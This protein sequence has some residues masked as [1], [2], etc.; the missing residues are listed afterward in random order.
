MSLG[1]MKLAGLY[2]TLLVIGFLLVFVPP[3]TVISMNKKLQKEEFTLQIFLPQLLGL[4]LLMG[5]M[6]G[7]TQEMTDEF[8]WKVLITFS[9][10]GAL[11]VSLVSAFQSVILLRWRS[12]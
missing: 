9:S 12:D 1:R 6:A 5:G 2:Y 11:F 7:V 4:L 10:A 8:S 3:V